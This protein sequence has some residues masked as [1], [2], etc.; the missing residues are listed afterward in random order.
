MARASAV[1]NWCFTLNNFS[2]TDMI[3]I[4]TMFDHGHFNYLLFGRE[5]GAEGTPHLQGYVQCKKR[6]RLKQMKQLLGP[7]CHIEQAQGNVFQN[8]LYCKKDGDFEE[9]GTPS[10]PAGNCFSL[11]YL[12]SAN[13]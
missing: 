8:Q 11:V 2:E 6:L 12:I 4:K 13:H 3:K 1:K 9:H 10:H 7:R 5:V